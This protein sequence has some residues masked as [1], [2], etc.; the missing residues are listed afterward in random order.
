[1]LALSPGDRRAEKCEPVGGRWKPKCGMAG[2]CYFGKGCEIIP[3]QVRPSD[4][5]TVASGQ[6]AEGQKREAG[7]QSRKPKCRRAGMCHLRKGHERDIL[8]CAAVLKAAILEV[9]RASCGAGE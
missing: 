5:S 1:M 8:R 9:L 7:G 3:P 4:S 2:M 6:K